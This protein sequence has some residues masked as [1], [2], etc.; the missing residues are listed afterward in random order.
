MLGTGVVGVVGTV[1]SRSL[2]VGS[3]GLTTASVTA[4][5]NAPM[6]NATPAQRA[7]EISGWSPS[8]A[9]LLVRLVRVVEAGLAEAILRAEVRDRALT[10]SICSDCGTLWAKCC[11]GI[12][13]RGSLELREP[14]RAIES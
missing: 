11:G 12:P 10:S 9:L 5:N 3:L 13:E 6:T 7:L 14:W 8:P 2:P 1:A 4:P